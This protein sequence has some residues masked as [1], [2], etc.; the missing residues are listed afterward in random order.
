MSRGCAHHLSHLSLVQAYHVA[1]HASAEEGNVQLSRQLSPAPTPQ[2]NVDYLDNCPESR[3]YY[4]E[5]K[6]EAGRLCLQTYCPFPVQRNSQSGCFV[7]C[8]SSDCFYPLFSVAVLELCI[9]L[10]V[11]QRSQFT[12]YQELI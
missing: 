1:R 8:L 11:T 3:R 6:K 4:P 9:P 12:F 10:G 7:A 2:F 5:R